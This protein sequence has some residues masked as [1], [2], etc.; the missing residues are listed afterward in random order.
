MQ[1]TYLVLL[2]TVSLCGCASLE[3]MYPKERPAADIKV[4]D[5][6]E[7]FS[8]ASPFSFQARNRY[9]QIVLKDGRYRL[10]MRDANGDYYQGANNGIE[11]KAAAGG[12][13]FITGGVFVPRD[14]TQ[15]CLVYYNQ[16]LTPALQAK[17]AIASSMTQELTGNID[18][19]FYTWIE[20]DVTEIPLCN[21]EK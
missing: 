13:D 4:I 16:S 21:Q 2:L 10:T 9:G 17:G 11:I 5:S 8:L 15:L 7:E 18:V 19:K 14:K 1:H 6:Q 12:S 20:K 3:S